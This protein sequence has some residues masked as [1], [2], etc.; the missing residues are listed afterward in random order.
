MGGAMGAIFGI[1]PGAGGAVDYEA[2][3]RAPS[4]ARARQLQASVLQRCADTGGDFARRPMTRSGP[5]V[6][7]RRSACPFCC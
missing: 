3:V 4:P 6:Y 2:A 5:R 7:A 1:M